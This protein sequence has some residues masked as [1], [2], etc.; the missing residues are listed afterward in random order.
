MSVREITTRL[1]QVRGDLP[2]LQQMGKVSEAAL[3]EA[4]RLVNSVLDGV[5]DK[6]LAGDIAKQA[7]AVAAACTD[8]QGAAPDLDAT[9]RAY[10]GIGGR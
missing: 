3:G 6:S 4:V 7:A 5:Q 10:Q 9:I 2:H 8:A 1:A